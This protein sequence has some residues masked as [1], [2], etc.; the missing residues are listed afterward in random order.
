[1]S[2]QAS[3]THFVLD[4]SGQVFEL[5]SNIRRHTEQESYILYKLHC[6]AKHVVPLTTVSESGYKKFC[7][8]DFLNI[9]QIKGYFGRNINAVK[10]DLKNCLLREEAQKATGVKI[11]NE[12]LDDDEE[13]DD[14]IQLGNCKF[15][16]SFNHNLNHNFLLI[17][18]ILEQNKLTIV[19][20]SHVQLC[21]IKLVG[22]QANKTN[23][24]SLIL[25]NYFDQI[26][27]T[28]N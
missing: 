6:N 13:E 18:I 2:A 8:K 28:S 14:D 23:Y 25:S 10:N 21:E 20:P 9:Q 17:Y 7:C 19:Y 4:K 1:M 16:D 26:E 27:I 11:Q 24:L 3:R 5:P 15:C 22:K 12:L